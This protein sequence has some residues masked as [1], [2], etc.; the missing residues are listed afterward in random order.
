[1]DNYE[2]FHHGVVGMKWGIRRYQNR[3]GTLTAAGKKRYNKELEK[4]KAEE[5]VLKNKQ[6]TKAKIE[7]LEAMKKANEDRKKALNGETSKED[8]KAAKKSDSKPKRPV[9][10]MNDLELKKVVTRLNLEERYDQLNPEK[11]S[12]GKKFINKVLNDVIVP[13]STEVAKNTLKNYMTD[14]IAKAMTKK[15]K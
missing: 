11:V 5:K 3:D 6:A 10:E 2:L 7:R 9:D 13:A 15:T 12:T 14:A 1:M 4:L 8:N